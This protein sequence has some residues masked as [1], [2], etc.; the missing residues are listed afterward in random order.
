MLPSILHE[1][2]VGHPNGVSHS[3]SM[4]FSFYSIPNILSIGIE[5]P[6]V[7]MCLTLAETPRENNFAFM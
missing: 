2:A 3:L 4:A 6:G 1:L 5:I 7:E